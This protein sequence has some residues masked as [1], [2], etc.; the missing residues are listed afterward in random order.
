VL[1]FVAVALA[2]ALASAPAAAAEAPDYLRELTSRAR[3]LRLA[4]RP[5]WL[6]LLHV[7]RRWTGGWKSQADARSFFLAAR[8]KTRPADELKADLAAFFEPVPDDPSVQH[9]QCRFPARY[10]WLKR[11]L[12]FDPARLPQVPCGR[13]DDWLGKVSAS[14]VTLVF[15]SSYMNN[16]ASLYGHTFLRV[17]PAVGG[18]DPLNDYALNFAADTAERNGIVFAVK[19]LSGAYP[20]RFTITPYYMKVQQYNN[21]ESRDLW[22]YDLA[23]DPAQADFLVRHLWEMGS[24]HFDYYFFSEN[25]SY[26]LLPLLEVADPGL[27][28]SR[29][30]RFKAIPA[31]TVRALTD[32]PGFVTAR[33]RRPSQMRLLLARRARL[34]RPELL[35]AERIARRKEAAP[36]PSLDAFPPERQAL[37]LESAYDLFRYRHGFRRFQALDKDEFERQLL[38]RRGALR[39]PSEEP[40]VPYG[41]DEVG[42][43]HGHRT[44]RVALGRGAAGG[45][46]FE[47][48][49]LRP[50]LH[51]LESGGEGF[52]AGSRLEMLHVVLRRDEDSDETYLASFRLLD[53]MSLAP[54]DRWVKRPSWRFF[55]GWDDAPELGRTAHRG[56]HFALQ[57]GTGPAW[58]TRLLRRELYYVMADAEAGAGEPFRDGYRV[59]AGGGG[60]VVCELSRRLRVRGEWGWR[61][62]PAGDVRN[63]TRAEAVASWSAARDW[64]VRG[65]ARRRGDS[66][67]TLFSVLYYL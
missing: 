36:F 9:P 5:G 55:A 21:M 66:T 1:F 32:R 45:R 58:E 23:L 64:E 14:A 39:L 15:A 17:G 47:E 6:R 27:D 46:P 33:R 25:C 4:E 29:R 43:E 49:S 18:R 48:L 19:G 34:D 40:S 37:V 8:G 61:R 63:V 26:Q 22:E 51:D 50:A 53:L 7:R 42:P 24:T 41:A 35:A 30:F 44:G 60:G 10:D 28:A 38:L 31:D 57:G 20:G 13:L 67:E 12:S 54:F 2:G 52:V 56:G 59:G 62:Y 65:T 11:E 3:E 16:P